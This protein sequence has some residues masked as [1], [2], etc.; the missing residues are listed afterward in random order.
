VRAVAGAGA[1]VDAD[2][3]VIPAVPLDRAERARL[4]AR[5]AGRALVGDPS[6]APAIPRNECSRRTG[7]RARRIVAG[8]ADDDDESAA[9]PAGR[10]HVDACAV[11]PG[12]PATT[13]ASVDSKLT[14]DA[15]VDVE[16][17]QS[18]GHGSP[19][20]GHSRALGSRVQ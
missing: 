2:E 15:T 4:S 7:S 3:R 16:D 17:G 14:P 8:A 11:R 6:N 20:F 13:G 18:F 19:F 9:H 12:V 1:A 5:A 10:A